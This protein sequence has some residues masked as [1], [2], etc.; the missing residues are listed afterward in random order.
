MPGEF[1][2]EL[3]F[4]DGVTASF[5]N[6]FVTENQQWIHVSGEAG[7][8]QIPDFVLP[9]H[10]AEVEATV[11][12]DAFVINNCEFHMEHH[13]QR[14]WVRENSSA[15]PSAQEVRLAEEFSK[16]VLSGQ[17]SD[18]WPKWTMDTQ[19]VLDAC[20]LSARSNGIEVEL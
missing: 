16:L 7:N 3:I 17:L 1:S 12:N 8:L 15:F 19:R 10:G 20:W 13:T 4:P 18:A 9:Y 2:A 14:H 6:S 11:T 5:Y